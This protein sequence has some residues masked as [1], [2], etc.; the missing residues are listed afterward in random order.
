M[1]KVT[2]LLAVTAALLTAG[3][4]EIAG[5]IVYGESSTQTP[6]V[7]VKIKTADTTASMVTD[8][9]GNYI[10]KFDGVSLQGAL[11]TKSQGSVTIF[12]NTINLNENSVSKVIVTNLRGQQVFSK[13]VSLG[14]KTIALPQ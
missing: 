13:T 2:S 8:Y 6:G 9:Y 1:K 7:L 11:E 10:F 5:K 12:N 14:E 4:S 3:Q